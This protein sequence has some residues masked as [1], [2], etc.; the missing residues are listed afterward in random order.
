[1][2][3]DPRAGGGARGA[4]PL[5]FRRLEAKY[6]VD[7][8]RRTALGR[9]LRAL[10]R[11][12]AHAGGDGSYLVRSLYFDTPDFMAYHEKL[13]GVAVRHK[14]RARVYGDPRRA[15]AVRLEVKSRA[16]SYVHKLAVDVPRQEWKGV[17]EA[18]LRRTAPPRAWLEANPAARE[19]FRIQRQWCMEPKILIE[20]RRE[21]LER[22]ELGRT[23]VNFDFD[24]RAARDL[25]LF[26]ELRAARPM[27]GCG[28]AIFEIKVDGRV[29]FW[30]HM[31]IAKYDLQNEAISKY[32]H[33]V[34]SEAWLSPS[35]RADEL[36]AAA[37]AETTWDEARGAVLRPAET[38]A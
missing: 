17:E 23:R 34:R 10:M 19:F 20:Y 28:R 21:A 1:L 2:T 22:R 18:L 36:A 37:E 26:G 3:S 7:R 9:D 25:D 12:D 24:L 4:I 14:L 6:L 11:P 15:P 8:P 16:L 32:C 27:L 30:L 35:A 33:G 13:Q 29:P 38:R 5:E 31:L